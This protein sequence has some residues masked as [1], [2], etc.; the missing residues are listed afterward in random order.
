MDGE[1]KRRLYALLDEI[2]FENI[3]GLTENNNLTSKCMWTVKIF[4]FTKVTLRIPL[5][6]LNAGPAELGYV[7]SVQTV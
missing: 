6:C 5:R 1:T 3:L 2:M 4:H 7:L